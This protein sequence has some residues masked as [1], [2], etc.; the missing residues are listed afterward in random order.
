MGWETMNKWTKTVDSSDM[1]RDLTDKARATERHCSCEKTKKS[2]KPQKPHKET[3][4]KF[5]ATQRNGLK[6]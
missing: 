3:V 2:L 6:V 4:S 5:K 1:I